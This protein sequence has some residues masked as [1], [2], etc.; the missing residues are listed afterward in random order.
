[1]FEDGHQE[2]QPAAPRE[3]STLRDFGRVAL[4]TPATAVLGAIVGVATGGDE[5]SGL[6]GITVF[7][8]AGL[9]H[10]LYDIIQAR[11]HR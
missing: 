2:E 10:A 4:E 5:T 1:M 8:I 11:R 6:I 3:P 9:G 7:G